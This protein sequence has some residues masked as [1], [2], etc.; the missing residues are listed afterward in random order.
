MPVETS[1]ADP[2]REDSVKL[3]TFAEV[4][5]AALPRL[6]P[7]SSITLFGGLA[8]VNPYPGSTMVSIVNGGLLRMTRKMAVE[9]PPIRMNGISPGLVGGLAPLASACGGRCG[10]GGGR[11]QGAHPNAPADHGRR[12]WR[13]LSDG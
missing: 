12:T 10:A 7:T 9:L 6:K 13:V 11:I 8:K 2:G 3:V 5:H 1:L 4:V